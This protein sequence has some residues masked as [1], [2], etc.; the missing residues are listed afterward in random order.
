VGA[1]YS[2][3]HNHGRNPELEHFPYDCERSKFSQV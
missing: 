1:D 3:L 2:G